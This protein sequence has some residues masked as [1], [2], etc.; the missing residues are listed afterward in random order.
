MGDVTATLATCR[1]RIKH[2][3]YSILCMVLIHFSNSND[4]EALN[5]R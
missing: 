5:N 3:I 2:R 4:N 1:F